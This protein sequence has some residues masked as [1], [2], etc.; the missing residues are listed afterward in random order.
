M[1]PIQLPLGF[2]TIIVPPL[3]PAQL[4]FGSLLQVCHISGV[5]DVIHVQRLVGLPRLGSGGTAGGRTPSRAGALASFCEAAA[6]VL[7]F[8]W[9]PSFGADLGRGVR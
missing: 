5:S 7:S 9:L 6:R 1:S 8:S 4:S 2:E 3:F